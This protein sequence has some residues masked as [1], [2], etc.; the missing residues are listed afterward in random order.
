MRKKNDE[1]FSGMGAVT[2]SSRG[3]LKIIPELSK[4]S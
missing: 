3:T 1:A 4:L 2:Y